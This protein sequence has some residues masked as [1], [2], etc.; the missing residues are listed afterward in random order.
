[1]K[2]T[3]FT[4]GIGSCI[5]AN[6]FRT[7]KFKDTKTGQLKDTGEFSIQVHFDEKDANVLRKI[8]QKEWDAYKETLTPAQQKQAKE[9]NFKEREYQ[10]ESYFKFTLPNVIKCR[11]GSDWKRTVAIFDA[12]KH[13]IF[14]D[15]EGIGN[16]SK[17][18]VAGE[19]SPFFMSKA[20]YGVSLRLSAIQVIDLK[21]VG[22]ETAES[23]GFDTEEGGFTT[24]VTNDLPDDED[25]PEADEDF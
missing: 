25:A 20:N 24:D 1:M 6:V 9:P 3:K 7:E 2:K 10:E 11:D 19:L 14:K 17:V 16:G 5:F 4:T 8:I 23:F 21:P 12:A 15:I 22:N 13:D 18:R